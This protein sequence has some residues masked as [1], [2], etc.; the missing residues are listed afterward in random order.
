M[1]IIFFITV[2]QSS[3]MSTKTIIDLFSKLNFSRVS[4]HTSRRRLSK[5]EFT[6]LNKRFSLM[7]FSLGIWLSKNYFPLSFLE[8]CVWIFLRYFIKVRYLALKSIG[9]VLISTMN[10]C[11]Y[12]GE[13][14]PPYLSLL[15]DL[16]ILTQC[17]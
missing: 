3:F 15:G 14:L 4:I 9:I 7:F 8:R 11:R 10:H 16:H 1:H 6:N 2:L 5:L 17:W 13:R 12:E